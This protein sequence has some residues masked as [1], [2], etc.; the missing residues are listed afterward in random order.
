[1]IE[2]LSKLVPKDWKIYVKEHV[3]QLQDYQAV[4]RSKL[5]EFHN[6]ITCMPKVALVP[7]IH[8]ALKLINSAKTSV[9]A[10]GTIGWE[11]VVRG[12]PTLLFGHSQYKN[13]NGFL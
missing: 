13:C 3:S 2:L 5:I 12:K 4:K 6:T 11:N 9:T 7:L 1:M 8:A 10:L